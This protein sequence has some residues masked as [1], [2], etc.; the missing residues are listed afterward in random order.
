MN[1]ILFICTSCVIFYIYLALTAPTKSTKNTSIKYLGPRFLS[2]QLPGF[3][4]LLLDVVHSCN[5]ILNTSDKLEST[6]R[7]EAVSILTNLLS[8]PDDLSSVSVLQ[9]EPNITIMN[10]C[11]DIKVT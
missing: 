6:P 11:P 2:L 5:D 8:L 4:L 1:L 7:I 3:T 10:N 9:P